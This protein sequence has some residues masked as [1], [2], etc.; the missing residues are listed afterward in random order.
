MYPTAPTHAWSPALAIPLS[1]IFTTDLGRH[2]IITQSPQ[3]TLEFTFDVAPSKGLD[4]GIIRYLS[5]YGAS[6]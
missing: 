4:K 3:I 6:H 5:L 1:R 2:I